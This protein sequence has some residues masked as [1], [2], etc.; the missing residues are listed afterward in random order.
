LYLSGIGA[1][2]AVSHQQRPNKQHQPTPAPLNVSE[3]A[4]P[5]EC[6]IHQFLP[7]LLSGEETVGGED[8]AEI[9]RG[10]NGD[11]RKMVTFH[12]IPFPS[13]LGL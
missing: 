1:N 13:A 10:A 2:G 7:Q 12:R 4:T 6:R 3:L 8:E 11:D 9:T 5:D